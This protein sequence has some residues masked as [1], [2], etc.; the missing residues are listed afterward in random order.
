MKQLGLHWSDLDACLFYKKDQN[1]NL[2]LLVCCHADNTLIDGRQKDVNEFK[3]SLKTYFNIKE[4]GT[5]AKHPG[6]EYTWL[7]SSSGECTLD[8]IMDDSINKII[9]LTES[10]LQCPVMLRVVLGGI[11][12]GLLSKD[13]AIID[14]KMYRKI[15][16]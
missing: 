8:A 16:G 3:A 13:G 1:G 7:L 4:L 15:L 6:I 11:N 14:N 2:I 5:H 12:K 10:Y 9:D